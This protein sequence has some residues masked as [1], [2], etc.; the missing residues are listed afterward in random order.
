M[1]FIKKNYVL[2]IMFFISLT[3][4]LIQHYFDLNWDFKSYV[5]NARY[6]FFNGSIF[7]VYRAPMTSFLLGFFI[8]IGKLGE[9]LYIIF[10]SLLFLYASIKISDALYE[11]YFFKFK[12]NKNLSRIVFYG[13][14][15]N[16]FTLYYG[17]LI[18]TELL[19][20]AFFNLFLVYFILNKKSGHL[21]GLACL[22]RYNFF[23]FAPL[24]LINKDYK[25]ILKNIVLFFITLIP[26]YLFNLIKWGNGFTSIIDSYNL[27][28]LS[29]VDLIE[30][31]S[32]S[33]LFV[34]INWLLPLFIIGLF[35]AFYYNKKYKGIKYIF[36]FILIFVLIIFDF[37][38]TPFK[39]TRYLF[40]LILP[41][42]FFSSI[43]IFYI[44]SKINISKKKI[45]KIISIL[46][47][48]IL[49]L[50]IV[51]LVFSPFSQSLIDKHNKEKIY[52]NIA[53]DIQES[54]LNNCY[55]LSSHW[56]L[57]NYYYPCS[58]FMAWNINKSL[59]KG[60]P[61]ILFYKMET[62]D[63]NYNKSEI[64]NYDY[65]SKTSDYAIIASKNMTNK[66]CSQWTGYDYPSVESPCKII[67]SKF[68]ILKL[69][70]F[71]FKICNKL[72]F[73]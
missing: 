19:G 15:L 13:L 5:L 53:E 33:Q 4:F 39:I 37:Y 47:I 30:T 22:T 63:D 66:T 12:I 65:I 9:Y 59:S 26:W 49:I 35:I 71:S 16:I 70:S 68:E 31:F 43:A 36:L 17:L 56:V 3:Y 7:E 54:N 55:F 50:S 1:S 6:L 64:D 14:I 2:L 72:N 62:I 11:K 38:H 61:V 51:N 45:N 48:G 42:T 25:K 40:N 57:I 41:I 28:I 44:Y 8:W 46:L 20:L 27:N 67:S 24:L 32:I 52:K 10:V 29:R 23:I 73:N 18:G 58:S 34:V 69:D 60:Y 21:L